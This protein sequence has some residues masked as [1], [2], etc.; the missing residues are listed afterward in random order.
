MH[1]ITCSYGILK[2]ILTLVVL[3]NSEDIVI[4]AEFKRRFF[5]TIHSPHP[6]ADG[7]DLAGGGYSS[8]ASC[9]A[10]MPCPL[11]LTSTIITRVPCCVS[12]S[13]VRDHLL[14]SI[15]TL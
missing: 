15:R 6:V 11:S 1:F 8:T 7:P 4:S 2:R 12:R 14:T 9:S 5:R 3:F 13:I 10:L